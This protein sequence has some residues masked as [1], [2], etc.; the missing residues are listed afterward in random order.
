MYL[1]SLEAVKQ[2]ISSSLAKVTAFRRAT[3][4]LAS[5]S[6]HHFLVIGHA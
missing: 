5:N 3:Q 6:G 4:F 1:H 2:A